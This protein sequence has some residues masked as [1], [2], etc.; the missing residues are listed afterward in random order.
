MGKW[1]GY[2][3][4]HNTCVI[5]RNRLLIYD[6]LIVY[7]WEPE[8]NF[9]MFSGD[10]IDQFWAKVDLKGRDRDI[11]QFKVGE[12]IF[13]TMRPRRIVLSPHSTRR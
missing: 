1:V 12:E 11:S 4:E 10:M 9:H 13:P 6:V 3:M 2:G 5:L 8:T 7:R